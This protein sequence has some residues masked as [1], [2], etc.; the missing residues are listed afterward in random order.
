MDQRGGIWRENQHTDIG[1]KITY[2]RTIIN[3]K[4]NLERYVV[5][6]TAL[7]FINTAIQQGILEEEVRHPRLFIAPVV[8]RQRELIDILEGTG[9]SL[10]QIT[11]GFHL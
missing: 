11:K 8:H 1:M 10:C 2:K 3:N 5:L 9:F 4:Q 6:Q 7:R